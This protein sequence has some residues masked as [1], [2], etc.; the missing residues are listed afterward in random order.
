MQR[1]CVSMGIAEHF[2]LSHQK[3]DRP[4][5]LRIDQDNLW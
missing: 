3:E 2:R 5:I 1:W 4:E